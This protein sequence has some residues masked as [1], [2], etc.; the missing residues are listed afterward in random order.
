MDTRRQIY[1]YNEYVVLDALRALDEGASL[2][3]VI[4]SLRFSANRATIIGGQGGEERVP[5]KAPPFTLA[6][7]FRISPHPS[8]R[9]ELG[10]RLSPRRNLGHLLSPRGDLGQLPPVPTRVPAIAR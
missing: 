9:D 10:H 5:V 7:P 1:T 3:R 8:P 2:D 4:D 6:P